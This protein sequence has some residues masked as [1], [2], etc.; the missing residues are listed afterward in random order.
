MAVESTHSE[1]SREIAELARGIREPG[2]NRRLADPEDDDRTSVGIFSAF[3]ILEW[4][5][6]ND[7]ERS[8]DSMPPTGIDSS[9]A[10]QPVYEFHKGSNAE[11]KLHGC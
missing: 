2:T 1:A 11:L 10:I 9:L 8:T 7:F 5:R 4:L 3:A 6:G